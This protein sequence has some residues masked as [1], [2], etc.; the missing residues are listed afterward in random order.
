[1]PKR[2]AS[3]VD[4]NDVVAPRRSTRRRA[5]ALEITPVAAP[6]KKNTPSS[7]KTGTK[8]QNKTQAAKKG[9]KPDIKTDK[10]SP[11]RNACA[12]LYSARLI[13]S[14]SIGK[15]SRLT[16]IQSEVPQKKAATAKAA[17]A[18]VAESKDGGPS[19]SSEK[20][21]WLMK[22][23][24]ETRLE[25]GVDVKFSVDDLAA[26]TEPEPWDGMLFPS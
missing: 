14:I 15:R 13:L 24:P 21:F 5:S 4:E 18:S 7:S 1:M 23:E 16:C 20:Q 17:K 6:A 8:K 9:V 22:A 10:P 25:N 11:V 19:S 12:H 3:A 2:K 26:K